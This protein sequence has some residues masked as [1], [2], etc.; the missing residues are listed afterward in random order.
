[1]LPLALALRLLTPPPSFA[2]PIDLPKARFSVVVSTEAAPQGAA[3]AYLL[4][5]PSPVKSPFKPTDTVWLHLILPRGKPPF[6]CVLVLPVMAAPN[7]W[8]ETRFMNRMT[9]EGLAVAW[10]E[11]PYQFH[12]RAL[13]SEPSGQVF[14]ARTARRL[15]FNFR[16]SALDARRA[17]D[18]L[19]RRTELDAR[20]T[21]LFGVSLGALVG[22]VVYS[23]DARPRYAAFML[24]GADFPSLVFA[25][26]MT[27]A[28]VK[29]LQVSPD[30]LREAWRGLDPLDYRER[31]AGKPALLVNAC[32]DAVIPAANA[33]RLAEA[34][35][36]ARQAWVPFGHYS[37]LLHLLWLP[38]LVARDLARRL[39][40][41]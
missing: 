41:P 17:L 25:S 35:P 6:P 9:A 23:V 27:G 10:L 11:M 33:R 36:A 16:Q 22:A 26:A 39:A 3:A 14:L 2:G 32:W 20:R 21:A 28:F 30:A 18:A 12:R 29:K 38:R 34:F 40:A 24:G 1:M 19:E 7:I 31:N 4:Q 15:A 13:P 37:S 5:F 8:I